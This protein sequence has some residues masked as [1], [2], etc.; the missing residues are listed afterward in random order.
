M[1]T[2]VRLSVRSEDHGKVTP[3]EVLRDFADVNPGWS[4]LEE[5]SRHYAELKDA[6]GLI[7][8][9]R[10]DA[11]TFVDLG[12]V[13]TATDSTTLELAVLDRTG[14]DTSLSPDER[15]ALLDTFLDEL[16]DY[17]SERPDHV[18]LHVE[19]DPAD[20]ASS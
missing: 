3:F 14:T 10:A 16:R 9:H 2:V 1:P 8:R 20:P 11:S 17:L 15:E 4:Y 12:F 7:L 18:T 13:G 5:D 19:R 6:P